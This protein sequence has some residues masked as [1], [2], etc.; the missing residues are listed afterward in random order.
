MKAKE[1]KE[2]SV[3]QLNQDLLAQLKQQFSLRMQHATGQLGNSSE[4]KKV[5][6]NIAR[7]KTVITEKGSKQ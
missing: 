6:R 7:I 3:E 2:K 1:L 4:L 5:R